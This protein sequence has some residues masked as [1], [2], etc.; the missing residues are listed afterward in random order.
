M[1]SLSVAVNLRVAYERNISVAVRALQRKFESKNLSTF[2]AQNPTLTLSYFLL[3][4]LHIG[5]E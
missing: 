5:F 1:A 2:F 4:L 3:N